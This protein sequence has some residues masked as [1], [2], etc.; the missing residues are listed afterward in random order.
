M[1]EITIIITAFNLQNFIAQCLDDLLSQS[2]SDFEAIVIDDC[3]TDD[4]R[5]IINAYAKRCPRLIRIESLKENLGCAAKVRNFALDKGLIKSRYAIFLDGDDRLEPSMLESLYK[6]A[7]FYEADI[8]ICAYD[9]VDCENGRILCKEMQNFPPF[10]DLPRSDC[11]LAFINGSIWN[12]LIRASI[13]E[14]IR[15]PCLTVGEDVCFSQM[16]YEKCRRISFIKNVLVHYQARDSSAISNTHP[17]MA[18]AFADELLKIYNAA[19]DAPSMNRVALV[20][21]IHIGVSMAIRLN[22]NPSADIGEYLKQ[23]EAYFK[24]NFDFFKKIDSM[25]F[26]CLRKHGIRGYAVWSCKLL[27]R[28]HCFRFFLSAYNCVVRF[29]RMD[30]KF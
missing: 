8:S 19:P 6:S 23:T 14:D 1:P 26:S 21:F 30:I 20:A 28:A 25:S 4:T 17:H 9:R 12:K 29:F 5:D 27:Y 15:F 3:S 13:L 2:F 10:I 7:E 11:I 24:N 22:N 18:Y 16:V